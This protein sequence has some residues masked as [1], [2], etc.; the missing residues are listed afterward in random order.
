MQILFLAKIFTIHMINFVNNS[1]NSKKIE[2]LVS[3]QQLKCV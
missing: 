3:I 2:V 1:R